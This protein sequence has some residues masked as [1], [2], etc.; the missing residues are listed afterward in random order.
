LLHLSNQCCVAGT[1]T[2]GTGTCRSGTEM[3]YGSGSGTGFESGAD[4]KCNKKSQ[5]IEKAGQLS[6]KKLI[7]TL[8][9]QD[10]FGKTAKYCL[11]PEPEPKFVQ[12][13][14]LNRNKSLWS[15]ST[16]SIVYITYL[17]RILKEECDNFY[18]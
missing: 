9:R 4:I 1:G 2:A 13:R 6:W 14:N 3:R 5:K 11:N 7:L 18:I 8:K 17:L 15:R 16:V 10:F 12:S